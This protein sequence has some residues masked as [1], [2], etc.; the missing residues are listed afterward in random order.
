VLDL[1]TGSVQA[2]SESHGG[3]AIV[4]LKQAYTTGLPWESTSLRG[5]PVL[6]DFW[7]Y[8]Q[9]TDLKTSSHF[10]YYPSAKQL[11][12]MA[13]DRLQRL[14]FQVSSDLF[15]LFNNA[16]NNRFF[17]Y[18]KSDL[19]PV[20]DSDSLIRPDAS[21]FCYE[22]QLAVYQQRPIHGVSYSIINQNLFELL[23]PVDKAGLW[24]HE[25]LFHL[26]IKKHKVSRFKLTSTEISRLVRYYNHLVFSDLLERPFHNL[27]YL[28]ALIKGG[29]L[30]LFSRRLK[31]EPDWSSY[32][33]KFQRHTA[34]VLIPSELS[35]D[36]SLALEQVTLRFVGRGQILLPGEIWEPGK[37]RPIHI[38]ER[39]RQICV[40]LVKRELKH[41]GRCRI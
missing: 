6:K 36:Q 23:G 12:M 15:N 30:K 19:R 38:S 2:G 41:R 35:F 25:L 1:G 40:N 22:F 17:R 32:P 26:L 39:D 18:T 29:Y 5:R 7:E 11:A 16:F 37:K 20:N 13:I 3:D 4:C 8:G 31:N 28:Q 27:Y 24:V 9:L 14:D 34:E 33:I 21:R 10:A